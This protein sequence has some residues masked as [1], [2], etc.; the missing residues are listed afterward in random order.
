MNWKVVGIISELI[1][2]SPFGKSE[3]QG[4]FT[5]LKAYWFFSLKGS[6]LYI[7]LWLCGDRIVRKYCF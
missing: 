6:S 4:L 7:L 3:G 2:K 1:Q 5:Y